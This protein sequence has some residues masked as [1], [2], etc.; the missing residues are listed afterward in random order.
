[1]R[2]AVIGG[3]FAGMETAYE[4]GKKGHQS[5]LF[6]RMSELGG[7]AGTFEIEGTRLERGYHHWFMS[8]THIVGLMNE[9]GLGDRVMW[10]PSTVGWFDRGKIWNMIKPMDLVRYSP[11]PFVDRMRLGL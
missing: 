6:E 4:L 2:I 10:L 5:F 3:G 1:M 11:L 8:D 9:L 7:L